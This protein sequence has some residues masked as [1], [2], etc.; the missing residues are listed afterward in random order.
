MRFR[1]NIPVFVVAAVMTLLSGCAHDSSR[2]VLALA[3][4]ENT[5]HQANPNERPG[6]TNEIRTIT[7]SQLRLLSKEM[8]Y[9]EV[10]RTL[11]NTADI[12]SGIYIFRYAYENGDFLD[13]NVI[14]HHMDARISEEFYQR[15]Q[16]LLNDKPSFQRPL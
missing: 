12:G 3:N 4:A 10:I 9:E 8:T 14:D 2:P 11:G 1:M 13:V 6:I 16:N 5:I 7:S 15:I